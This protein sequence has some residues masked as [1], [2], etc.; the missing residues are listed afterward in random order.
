M[1]ALRARF[2]LPEG[3]SSAALERV[4]E[5]LAECG[6]T[7]T[8]T[9]TT[10]ANEEGDEARPGSF[11]NIGDVPIVAS[12]REPSVE[13]VKTAVGVA[14]ARVA[15][16]SAKTSKRGV[17]DKES[18]DE[19]TARR[20]VR[21]AETL[22]ATAREDARAAQ[23]R[24]SSLKVELRAK[25]GKT[26]MLNEEIEK[27]RRENRALRHERVRATVVSSTRKEGDADGGNSM[28]P[29]DTPAALARAWKTLGDAARCGN[30]EVALL[31]RQ[32]KQAQREKSRAFD[33]VSEMQRDLVMAR[34]AQRALETRARDSV[35]AHATAEAIIDEDADEKLLL[36][37]KLK[38]TIEELAT[39]R[40]R[41]ETQRDAIEASRVGEHA[42]RD[43][44]R[45]L[46]KQL[47]RAATIKNKYRDACHELDYRE[48]EVEELKAK[49][50]HLEAECVMLSEMVR[51]MRRSS[52]ASAFEFMLA[53][54]RALL[55]DFAPEQNASADVAADDA[56][57]LSGYDTPEEDSPIQAGEAA[58]PSPSFVDD[59]FPSPP[60]SAIVRDV[61]TPDSSSSVAFHF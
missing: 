15:A 22:A 53:A 6:K 47:V 61:G 16:K 35:R 4:L 39:L 12:E 3:T 7:S 52:G 29:K 27:L 33:K 8:T 30:A 56:Q 54:E 18:F 28:M 5:R 13:R 38:E 48:R 37:G 17:E 58:P 34:E 25:D 2:G 41:V 42:L 9:T 23:K 49:N 19:E 21:D 57:S 14:R 32:Y 45:Q 51:E 1:E 44:I 20:R 59:D 40:V 36:R 31:M 11:G 60:V 24:V 55:R 26:Q 46:E 50:A 10:T 43:E